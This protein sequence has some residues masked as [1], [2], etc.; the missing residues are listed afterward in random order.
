M[1]N[2][3]VDDTVLAMETTRN[4]RFCHN[5]A[6][7]S[8][9]GSMTGG[10]TGNITGII[11]EQKDCN[12]WLIDRIG[13]AQAYVAPQPNANTMSQEQSLI[14]GTAFSDLV[15]PYIQGSNLV[16]FL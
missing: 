4:C 14:C 16:K 13:L 5:H 10:M 1:C 8:M 2:D 6:T 15:Q 9:T 7:G 3:F 12:D 11:G